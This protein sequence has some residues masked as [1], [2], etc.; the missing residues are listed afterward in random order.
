MREP[1]FANGF[2]GPGQEQFLQVL[3]RDEAERRFRAAIDLAPLGM[4]SVALSDALGR[5]LATDVASP[6]DVPSFD[7]ANVDGFAVIAEDTFGASE[8]VPRRVRLA[9]EVIHTAVVPKTVVR[10]GEAVA[11]ATGGMMPRGSDAVVMIEHADVVSG[12]VNILHAATA[13][14]GV[15]FAGTDITAGET[16]LRRGTILTSR[17]TGVLAAIGVAS[18]EVWRK[19][20]VAILS[21][22]DEIIPPGQ[23]MQPARIYD[24]NAQVLADAVREIGG[25]PLR[26]GIVADDIGLLRSKLREALAMSD[27]VLLSGGTSKGAGDVSYRVVSELCD[28]GIV[29]HGVALKPGKPICLAATGGRP[30]VVLPG[31][32][33]SAI[34]TFHEF[35]APVLSAM[36]GRGLEERAHVQARLAVKVNSEIGR[37]EYLLVGLVESCQIP[38]PGSPIPDPYTSSHSLSLAAYPMGQGSGSVTTF[39][40]ADGFTTIG[41]HEEIVAAGTL[42]DVQL[43]GRELQLADL[44]VIGSHCVGLDYLLGELEKTG[45]RSKFLAVGSLAGLEAAKRGECD[46]AG[47]HLLDPQTGEY[48]RPFL[49][50]ALTLIPGYGRLQGIVFRKGDSRFEGRRAADAIAAASADPSCVMVNRNQGS[51]TRALI[52]RLLGGKKPSG[53][54]VQPRNHNAVVAAVVQYRADWGMTLDTIARNAGLGFIPVQREQYDF[55]SPAS[56]A[57]RPAVQAF[58]ARLTDPATR[59]ALARL[60][61]QP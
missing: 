41:R 54:A 22:G 23:P 35:V 57:S 28:P 56:R 4:E 48:N 25:E 13:G 44:V 19:P 11:I 38:D 46:I 2:G 31:F 17:D 18:V 60:G 32:P 8:E 37:T 42:V 39:S 34:F 15:S 59:E 16:V 3:D 5:V 6:V 14:S 45:V 26:L 9:D 50:P 20:V 29:A 10:S 40:R 55:V 30:V 21:T 24:S 51:G 12:F 49:T 53:Y 52:D 61:M 27:A 47:V 43:L 33:T 1:P 36:A 58:R 7:R